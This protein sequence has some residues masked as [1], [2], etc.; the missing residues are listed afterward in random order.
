MQKPVEAPSIHSN[1]KAAL[2]HALAAIGDLTNARKILDRLPMLSQ[3]YPEIADSFSRIMHVIISKVETPLRPLSN[4]PKRQ[5]Q[6]IDSF[7][8]PVNSLDFKAC[9][10]PAIVFI[11]KKQY[12]CRIKFFYDA[13]K[14]AVPVF[15]DFDNVLKYLRVILL[16]IGPHLFRDVPLVCK[17]I[18]VGREHVR[19]V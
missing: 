1:Q 15:E 16:N 7:Q 3:V 19:L 4:F 8:P 18:R 14:D 10:D 9:Q 12:Y 6:P 5:T 13:W 17:L 2:V 11:G